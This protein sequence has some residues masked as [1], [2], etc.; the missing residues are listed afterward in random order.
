M[1]LVLLSIPEF[2][3]FVKGFGERQLACL[4][5]VQ[6]LHPEILVVLNAESEICCSPLNQGLMRV[7]EQVF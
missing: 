6:F 1:S 2:L 3:M 5:M 4:E 7:L